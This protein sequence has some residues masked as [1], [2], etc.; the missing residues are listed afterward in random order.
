MTPRERDVLEGVV[1]GKTSRTIA[2][3]LGLSR[4]TVEHHRGRIMKKVGVERAADLIREVLL[5]EGRV[6]P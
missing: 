5:A 2:A 6:D 3:D 4:K 1:A